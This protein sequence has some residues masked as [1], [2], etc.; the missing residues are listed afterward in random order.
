MVSGPETTTE[1]V[2]EGI[3]LTGKRALVTGA[4]TGIG[5]ETAR[6]L[7]SHGAAVTLAGRSLAR[8]EAAAERIRRSTGSLAV[9]AG[10]L[11]LSKPESVRAFCQKVALSAGPAL[12]FLSTMPGSRR[13]RWS[14]LRKVA[15]CSSPSIT[16]DTSC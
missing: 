7:A 14:A 5:E 12:T 10:E 13:C 6:A 2:L 4:S 11:E 16:W 9:D 15:R 1:E 8:A 3:D